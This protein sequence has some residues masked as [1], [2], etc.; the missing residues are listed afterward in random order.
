MKTMKFLTY[1]TFVLFLGLSISSCSEDGEDGADG[2][3]GAV[4]A[5]GANGTDGNANVQ[6]F[7]F[8]NPT[9][10]SNVMDLSM[11]A[12]TQ[13]VWDNDLII[14]YIK[15]TG[16]NPYWYETTEHYINGYFRDFISV[17][18]FTI[19]AHNLDGS[20]DTTPPE[21]EKVK[22][23]IIES[24]DTTTTDGNGRVASPKEAV[25]NELA[26]ANVDVN[27]YYEVCAYYGINPE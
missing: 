14:G 2:A 6:T 16:S 10:S 8:T 11:P 1:A 25:Y 23:L 15:L 24:T 5:T 13:E 21:T 12:I 7:I 20:I 3:A 26:A 22:I 27:D 18:E 17:G 4:G 9:W 19:K